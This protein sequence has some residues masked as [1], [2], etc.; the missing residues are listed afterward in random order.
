MSVPRI[1]LKAAA[2]IGGIHASTQ[3]RAFLRAHQNTP[4][5][6]DA[7]LKQMLQAHAGS[8]FGRDHHFDK[9][10]DYKDFTAAVPI[11]S[12]DDFHPYI[13]KVLAG[14]TEA[15]LPSGDSVRMFSMTSGTTGRPK[16]IPV[17]D[18]FAAA[19]QRG[20]NIFG[21]LAL[22]D[23]PQAWL[24]PILQISSPMR[25]TDS[26]THLPCGAI[27]GLLA[28]TQK[29]IVKRM[30]VVPDAVPDITSAAARYYTILRCGVGRDVS[31][32]TTANPSS[33]IKLIE[34]GQLYC[35]Q[36][37]KDVADGTF[38]P[39]GEVPQ[40]ISRQ[41]KF[42]PNRAL[43]SRLEQG[44]AK[45]GKLLPKHFWDI[46]FL[47]NWT[48]GTLGLYLPRLREL[49]DDA[50]VRDIG[51]LASEGRFSIPLS[52]GTAGGVAD[53]ES[54]FLEFIPASQHGLANPAILR[55]SQVEVGEE[56]FL[57]FS[58]WTGLWRYNL[59]D[60]VRVTGRLGQ[61]PIFEFLY[62]GSG[63]ANITGEK[64]TEHQVVEAMR[65]SS[66][67]SRVSM[68]RFLLQGHFAAQPYYQLTVDEVDAAWACV[69]AKLLDENLSALNIE[70][71]SKRSSGRLGPVR[72]LALPPL[73]LEKREQEF[74][75]KRHGRTEQ[76]KHQYLLR[77][78]VSD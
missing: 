14:Q 32:I 68:Q 20:W 70:Y 58:N 5:Q 16:Y 17:T 41:I 76:Y 72:A 12:Y 45:D 23:H 35:Q 7:L 39:P 47:A 26:P 24:R 28:Q 62:R 8:Q 10:A 18:R 54:N 50:P 60:C 44:I 65:L 6:Q 61:S 4:R 42:R 9:I 1:F 31:F 49:F 13:D 66:Q 11:G 46:A 2:F 36:L 43:A 30:Y 63:T 69:L 56:Y 51:L 71:R 74:I 25:E 15:L 33:T 73:S 77:D 48:G 22:K 40:A 21:L 57:V 59:D 52:D 19:M 34:I 3:V 67:A 55:A 37:I 75:A 53:I 64:I 27:S 38:C 78:V 29:T